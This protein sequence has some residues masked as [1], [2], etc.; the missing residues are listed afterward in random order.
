MGKHFIIQT[1]DEI[2]TYF[3]L[4]FLIIIISYALH[5]GYFMYKSFL[6]IKNIESSLRTKLI[7]ITDVKTRFI[8]KLLMYVY[9]NIIISINDNN[10]LRRI[11]QAN[12][13]TKIT[14]LIRSTGGIISSSDS[15]L[16][17]LD[18]HKPKKIAYVPSYAMSAATLLTLAC[19]TI[20]MNKYAAIG[21]TDPQILILD[22]MISF[23]AICR[24]IEEKPIVKIKDNI[25]INYYENKILYDDNINC[26][27][28]YINKH[29]K[30]NASETDI[31]ELIQKFSYGNIPHHSEISFSSLDKV[32]NINNT[33]TEDI[34]STYKL[35]N[36][37]F[38]IW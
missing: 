30:K 35:L 7:Y 16:N 11:L 14:I 8:D 27:T 4:I 22:E 34:L 25:L 26:V 6:L 13:N 2:I 23:R 5:Y 33:I 31:N 9:N 20:H 12:S 10:S 36:Y 38:N 24:L 37:I 21:P 15:M 32:I 17:L 1:F 3:I 29:K 28:K 18:N 19:D